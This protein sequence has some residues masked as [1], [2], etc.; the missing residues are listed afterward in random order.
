[1]KRRFTAARLAYCALSVISLAALCA[2]HDKTQDA[3]TENFTAAINDF[4]AKRGHLCVAKYDWPIYVTAD[5]Q[6]AHSRDAIQM[7]VLEKLGIVAGKNVIV[8]RKD[9]KGNKITADAREYDLTAEGQKYYLHI[10][11]VVATATSRVTHPAD[12]CAATLTLDKV[13]GWE[14]PIAQNGET[15]TSALYTYKID[16]APWARDPEA[17]RVFPMISR[18]IEG[19]GTMQLREGM[20]LTPKGWVADEIFHR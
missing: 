19:E 3:S 2:C 5:D 6:A 13:V 16:P 8:E 4:L 12:L 20:H 9:E 11:V 7:P 15:V 14:P 1:M 17:R 10:P 18:V